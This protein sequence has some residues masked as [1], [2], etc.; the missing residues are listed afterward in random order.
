[1]R[2]LGFA[3]AIWALSF[4]RA[5]A[6]GFDPK[7]DASKVGGCFATYMELAR[8][9][10]G[11]PGKYDGSDYDIQSAQGIKRLHTHVEASTSSEG[12]AEF[13]RSSALSRSQ[14]RRT[15]DQLS[16]GDPARLEIVRRLEVDAQQCD[17]LV[18]GWSAS[19]R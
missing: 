6:A 12:D 9:A 3:A 17:E 1:M 7:L 10:S 5:N 18:A 4:N 16:V 19:P 2:R 15:I 14:L 11:L 13:Y 8:A